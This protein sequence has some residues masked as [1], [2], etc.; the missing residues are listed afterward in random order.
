LPWVIC[1]DGAKNMPKFVDG[2]V[3]EMG[4]GLKIGAI[5]GKKGDTFYARIYIP[6]FEPVYVSLK[7][8]YSEHTYVLNDA[9]RKAREAYDLKI[10]SA[11]QTGR[12][13]KSLSVFQVIN[14]YLED[15]K[16]KA[17][18][19]QSL[20]DANKPPTFHT[21]KTPITLKRYK[22]IQKPIDKYII[23]FFEDNN[24]RDFD[25]ITKRDLDKFGD[26]VQ[27]VYPKIGAS[28]IVTVIT[29][30]RDIWRYAYKQGWCED[31]P[32]IDRPRYNPADSVSR[33]LKE[34]E[35]MTIIETAK[36]V[37]DRYKMVWESFHTQDDFHKYYRFEQFYSFL[38]IVSNTGFRPFNGYNEHTMLKWGDYVKQEELRYFKRKEKGLKGYLALIDPR[39]YA[40]IDK[41]EE[42][43]ALYEVETDYLFFHCHDYKHSRGQ[44]NKGDPIR[45]FRY[46][47]EFVLG[48][49]GLMVATGTSRAERL[50]PYS[51]RQ[52]YITSQMRYGTVSPLSIAKSVN[53]SVRMLSQTYYD[54]DIEKE[55]ER[56]TARDIA[57]NTNYTRYLE[58]I[59]EG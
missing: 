11:T 32:V 18:H 21:T 19:N 28:R 55:A 29:Y 6:S 46:E 17:T 58:L 1:L 45:G 37:R 54:F 4:D 36:S 16:H 40:F 7:V 49:C 53:T 56:L 2:T 57:N 44:F 33:N 20:I 15:Y 30:I 10:R 23:R 52:Y 59:K 25:K 38:H 9:M 50:S 41:L 13:S 14:K 35:F 34:E 27:G 8:P 31:V 26:W 5:R 48:E 39:A 22:A 43:K 12:L 42:L 3:V 24:L 51:L 47:W